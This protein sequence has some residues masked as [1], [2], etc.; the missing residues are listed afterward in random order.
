MAEKHPMSASSRIEAVLFDVFGTVVDWRT[1]IAADLSAFGASRGID[2]DWLQMTDDWRALYQ[3]SLE[4][5]RSG[6]RPWTILDVLHRET[7]VKLIARHGI[8]GLSETDIDH[9]NRAWHRLRPWPDSVPGLRRLEQRYI[10][11][12]LSNGNIALLT[13]MA[14]HA[15]LPWDVILGA[16][17]AR[18]Y[19]PLPESYLRN[20]ALLDLEPDQVMLA[21]AHNN[22][23]AA[24]RAAGLATAFVCR[25]TE[26]GPGQKKDL[27]PE[28][29]WDVIT[30]SIT[31]LADRLGCPA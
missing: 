14:K 2:A 13:R 25:P 11:G 29:P 21:A 3:P 22:D 27:A 17:T 31:G 15:G 24:A 4:E 26:Y 19:K 23:L 20:V 10:I 7:L 28:Q 5:V 16:E 8:V 9:L 12:P 6:R 1:S 18:A 30:D